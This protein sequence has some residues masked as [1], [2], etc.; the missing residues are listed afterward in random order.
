MFENTIEP[1]DPRKR[2]TATDA[3][4][5]AIAK[6][7]NLYTID[8][9]TLRGKERVYYADYQQKSEVMRAQENRITTK[10]DDR[11]TVSA[12]LDLAQDRGWDR[13]RLR[14]SDS[15]RREAWVQAQVRGI[16]VSGYK[17]KDT[18]L[19]E[20]ARR[21]SAAKPVATATEQA[22]APK[23]DARSAKAPVSEQSSQRAEEKAVWG[24][25]ET[26][27]KAAREQDGVAKPAQR[28]TNKQSATEAA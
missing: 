23:R 4:A 25:V 13:I 11:Q 17:P 7:H 6:Q 3:H 26:A 15:F 28:S 16:E 8:N 22:A 19:Q 24:A 27:G 20:A 21:Q 9:R 12:V 2:P 18:D 10:L 5:D 1:M 14:G